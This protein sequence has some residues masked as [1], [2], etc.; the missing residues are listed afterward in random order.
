MASMLKS[1][2]LSPARRTAHLGPPHSAHS[3]PKEHFPPTD[4]PPCHTPG[5]CQCCSRPG[6]LFPA[7]PTSLSRPLLC[8]A[9][10]SQGTLALSPAPPLITLMYVRVSASLY[11]QPLAQHLVPSRCSIS[12]CFRHGCL[13]TECAQ[14]MQTPGA[15]SRSHPTFRRRLRH[16]R[17][18]EG[19]GREARHF[20]LCT[21]HL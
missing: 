15:F 7:F 2:V 1:K 5:L 4:M 13:N 11:S 16:G 18:S 20:T 21:P 14:R 6:M 17:N 3:W 10:A 19:W 12:A 9:A 8:S